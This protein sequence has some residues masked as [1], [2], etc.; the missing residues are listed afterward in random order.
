MIAGVEHA[1]E[2]K[3]PKAFRGGFEN[4]K[5]AANQ[6]PDVVFTLMW[7]EAGVWR[8]QRILS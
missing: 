3:G 4:L 7:E 8:N 6:W 1:W 2:A 5:I